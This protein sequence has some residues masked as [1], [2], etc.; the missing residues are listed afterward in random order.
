MPRK[1]NNINIDHIIN[2]YHT[3]KSIIQ[4]AEEINIPASSLYNRVKRGGFTPIKG[5]KKTRGRVDLPVNEIIEIYESG[6][7]IKKI[8]KK[9]NTS[10]TV[11][12]H[13]LKEAGVAL[14]TRSEQEKI[15]WDRMTPEQ[16]ESQVAAAHKATKGRTVPYEAKVKRAKT[17]QRK[18][19]NVSDYEYQVAKMLRKSGMNP[20]HQK[21]IGIYNCDLVIG[22]VA[23]EI[24]GG[25]FHW[26]G[27]HLAR[28]EKRFRYIM[29]CG[30][31]ILVIHVTERYPIHPNITNYVANM[32]D[33]SSRN[34]SRTRKYR[35][36]QGAC[37]LVAEGSA[38]DNH[39][40]IIPSFTRGRDPATGRYQRVPR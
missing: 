9:F 8:A 4:I 31:D 21:P 24:F 35:V 27:S 29:D 2:E 38:D 7:S 12:K 37:E 1:I 40:S 30:Y 17:V 16:R 39:I 11:V 26:Y 33:F 5:R 36:V 25:H 19:L 3:G 28:T 23:V 6:E 18:M 22:S 13:R 32:L 10:R 15:K 34:P 14:R 20:I